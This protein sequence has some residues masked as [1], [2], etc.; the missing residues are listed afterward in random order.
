MPESAA[1]PHGAAPHSPGASAGSALA[2]LATPGGRARGPMTLRTRIVA[3]ALLMVVLIS[4]VIGV[5]SVATL[6]RSL[7]ER[8]DQQLD[9]AFARGA[10]VVTQSGPTANFWPEVEVGG[11]DSNAILNGPAQAPGT[12]AV[13]VASGTLTGGYLGEDGAVLP[14]EQGHL[15]ALAALPADGLP[16]SL[17]L[18]AALGEY[19]V[20]GAV[21]NGSVVI[22]GLPLGDVQSTVSGLA[23]RVA[24]VALV[25]VIVLATIGTVLIRRELRPLERVAAL[26]DGI[27]A[28]D[29]DRGDVSGLER[30]DV[31]GV[32]A[33]SE[34]GRVLSAVNGM[35]GNV[36]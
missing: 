12:L 6:N 10:D 15:D 21:I 23:W 28:R 8:L 34:V 2:A 14:V 33:G 18:G 31:A 22:V 29:L 26:A 11:R 19:R 30:L 36:E 13:V 24:G 3:L 27:A 7:S 9:S 25:G 17:G 5:V 1:A 32:D 35:V 16:H 20:Q 4:A